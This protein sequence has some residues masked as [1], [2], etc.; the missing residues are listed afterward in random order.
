MKFKN[1]VKA[2]LSEDGGI[3]KGYASTF[4]REP[5]SYGDIVAPGAFADTLKEWEEKNQQGL[6]I[7]LL[8]GH[9]TYD[10]ESNIGCIKLAREDERGLYVE[11]VFDAEN[12][13]AQYVRKLAMEGRVYQFSFAYEVTEW[14]QVELEDGR[15][16]NELRKLKLYE[17]SVVQIPANQHATIEEVKSIKAG[18]RNS[19]KDADELQAIKERAQEIIEAVNGLLADADPEEEPGEGEP[20]SGANV[21]E[22]ETEDERKQAEFVTAYKEAIK[23]IL[24]D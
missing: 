11:G 20:K 24:E 18:R 22:D 16:A 12:E 21:R 13:R 19:A 3:I 7:P 15:N 4:D 6:Y 10:P 5:D 2:E 9:D 14:G 1:F 8:W 17:V 23:Q